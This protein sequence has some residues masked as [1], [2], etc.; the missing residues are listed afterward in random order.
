MSVSRGW[1]NKLCKLNLHY[2]L[3]AAVQECVVPPGGGDPATKAQQVTTRLR[4]AP[5][6]VKDWASSGVS[7]QPR[8]HSPLTLPEVSDWPQ[9]RCQA[10]ELLGWIHVQIQR[11]PCSDTR[12]PQNRTALWHVAPTGSRWQYP[13][14]CTFGYASYALRRH[15]LLYVPAVYSDRYDLSIHWWLLRRDPLDRLHLCVSTKP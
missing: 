7:R 14:N 11:T 12:R 8:P 1:A 13:G 4:A 6:L 10:E 3:Y 2:N 9:T 15:S 5:P